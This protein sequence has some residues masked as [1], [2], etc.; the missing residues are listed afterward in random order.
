M[1]T[2][3]WRRA[4]TALIALTFLVNLAGCKSLMSAERKKSRFIVPVPFPPPPP[5]QEKAAAHNRPGRLWVGGYWEWLEITGTYRWRPGHYVKARRNW[6]YRRAA[7]VNK[8]GQWY[9]VRPHWRRRRAM[10]RPPAPSAAGRLG[11]AKAP[12]PAKKKRRSPVPSGPTPAPSSP[13]N[14]RPAAR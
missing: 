8:K 10:A 7:Y 11:A 9:F 14:A 13:V 6:E 3:R 1:T 2:H 5:R 4:I 12:P